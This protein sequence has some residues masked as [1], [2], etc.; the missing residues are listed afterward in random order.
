MNPLG[1]AETEKYRY[2]N[3]WANLQ[4]IHKLTSSRYDKKKKVESLEVSYYISSLSNAEE[5]YKLI[6]N[7]YPISNAID[8]IKERD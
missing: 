5:V 4:S 2:L 8:L 3:K 1:F 7:Y 6:R